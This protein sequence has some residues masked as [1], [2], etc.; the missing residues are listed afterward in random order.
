MWGGGG[1]KGVQRTEPGATAAPPGDGER[2][3]SHIGR[4]GGGRSVPA[5]P[6]R[7]NVCVVLVIADRFHSLGNT[8][9]PV[10]AVALPPQLHMPRPSAPAPDVRAARQPAGDYRPPTP[11]ANAG[12]RTSRRARSA[13]ESAG[14]RRCRGAGVRPAASST[15]GRFAPPQPSAWPLGPYRRSGGAPPAPPAG[16]TG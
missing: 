16:D 7:P 10:C 6:A 8:Y 15:V 11:R 9:C 1:K 3:Q 2:L 12:Y 4:R 14:R 13:A 5:A